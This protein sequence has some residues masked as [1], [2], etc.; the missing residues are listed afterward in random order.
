[1][2]QRQNWQGHALRWV[3][4][5]GP[6]PLTLHLVAFTAFTVAG[7]HVTAWLGWAVLGGSALWMESNTREPEHP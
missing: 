2:K 1:M 7:F 5:N 3:L 4:R 6:V